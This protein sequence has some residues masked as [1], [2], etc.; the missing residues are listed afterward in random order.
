M[1]YMEEYKFW[2]EDDYFNQDTKNEL[3]AIEGDAAEIEE[4]FYK[5]LEFG[6]GGMRGIIG[7]GTNRMNIY[8]VRK[9]TQG[10][11][12]FILKQGTQAKGV[13]ISYDNRRMS[14]EFADVA[15]LCLAANGIKAYIFESLRPTP[16]L[17]FALRTLGCTAGIMV[18]A[19]HNPPEY[20]GYK[21]YWEDGA[22][23]TAPKDKEIITEVLNI[24]DYHSLKTMDKDEAVKAG[25]YQV[26]GKE[27]DDAYMVELKKQIIH[28]DIIAEVANDIKIVYTPLCGTG[29]KPVQRV[30]SELG[31]KN[32]YV[33]PEQE[34]PDPNFTTLE[35]PNPEDPKAFTYAL[36]L[37]KEKDADIVLATDP[38]ADRL[39][40]YAKDRKTGEYVAFTGNMSGM[41]IAEYIL[42]EKT[43]TGT[44]PANPAMVTTI[45]TTNMTFPI[46]AG[47]GV[48]LIEVL[49]GFKFIGEQI[50]LFE[51][52]GSNNYVFGLEESY[53]CL[54]GTHA[55][56]KDAIVA[57]MCL[58]EVAS[59]CKKQGKTLWDMMLEMYEK[60][61]Y[62]KESQYTITLKGIDGAKQIAEIMDKLRKN[63]PKAFGDLKV[64][65]FRD[66]QEDVVLDM[67]TGEKTSTGLP[68]S[69][70]LYFELPDNNWCCAR[71]SGTEPKIKFYIGVKGDS[72][73]DAAAKNAKLTED[74]K[75]LL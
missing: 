72:I 13:A 32:V 19:S 38:D 6:T 29:N 23:V 12:N 7:A 66:Y 60:Y 4:R 25:L 28:P 14:T 65:K 33:V 55:R 54:A 48:K 1:G 44:M 45:V 22:Q 70:V 52:T 36:N 51:Q 41:L 27:I 42:R 69:N 34:N 61:G 40:V 59:F 37:A 53:G 46:T 63:P 73:E 68:R 2:L 20:N 18:T 26:I 8:T 50:K 10:L 43:A 3:K 49:T 5:E 11:A 56:D 30:L 31:F 57:V 9:A 15:A 71:P 39:G 74:I 24:T 62:F 75:A 35:Y 17:S 47:Y 58:C 67:E 21:V 64:L 16:E